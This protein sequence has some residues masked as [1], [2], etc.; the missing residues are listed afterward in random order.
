[1][2]T[3]RAIR[4]AAP[5][6]AVV[7]FG[8]G[9]FGGSSS[10][11]APDGGI[12]RT[13]TLGQEWKQLKVL[14]L[15]AQTK[16]LA[17]LGTVTLAIDPQDPLAVYVGT[18]E[19]GLLFSLDGGESFQL[20]KGLSTGRVNAVAI[21]PKDKCAVYAAKAN[22]IHKTTNCSRDWNQVYFDSR[23]DISFTAIAVDH[24]N[25]MILFGGTSDGDLFR[26][27]DAGSSW[28]R[29]HR[30]D[31][32]R[33]QS[34]VIDPRDSRTL[35]A[36]TDGQ[37]LLKTTDGGQTWTKIL[38]PFKE[39]DYARRPKA[40]VID[41]TT[42]G[43]VYT[44][45]KYGVIRSDDGGATWR[46]LTLPTPAGAVEI[47]AM[48]IH[49]KNSKVIVYATDT[50]IVFSADAGATWTPKKLP[51][52]RGVSSLLFDRAETPGLF[53]GVAPVKK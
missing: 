20:A 25:P 37:G 40:V 14:S 35:F 3:S 18:V 13:K 34:L 8:Q 43:V 46:P 4:L 48:A 17:E 50:S 42:A 9:C 10:S 29:V 44:I 5:L 39:W 19:N 11:T 28:R 7:L 26:S 23:T 41:P 51:T 49:P 6:L 36:A 47:K 52:K 38:D 15:G 12:Y 33:I 22:Q 24:Y 32:V 31:G 27:E 45:S 53:L 16:S 30:V 2:M 1:M 21:D